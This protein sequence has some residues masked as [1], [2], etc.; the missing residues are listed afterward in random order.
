M[1]ENKVYPIAFTTAGSIWASNGWYYG[2]TKN[3]DWWNLP[4]KG[5]LKTNYE[6]L[7]KRKG[8]YIV[9][10]V[11][12]HYCFVRRDDKMYYKR[13]NKDDWCITAITT[14]EIIADSIFVPSE[15][16]FSEVKKATAEIDTPG[17]IVPP[18]W[19]KLSNNTCYFCGVPGCEHLA[20]LA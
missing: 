7:S 14:K 8:Y 16:M 11:T 9:V 6:A 15:E 19:F 10:G 4:E 20:R 18:D 3:Y 1:A 12:S 2:N 5:S 17:I 13:R